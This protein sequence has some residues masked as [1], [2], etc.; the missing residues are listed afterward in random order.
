M[1]GMLVAA[2]PTREQKLQKAIHLMETKGDVNAALPLL[3]EAA[4]SSDRAVAARALLSLA[5]AQEGQ[6]K[7][8][9]R[10]TYERIAKDYADQRDVVAQARVRLKAMNAPRASIGLTARQVW[11]GSEVDNEGVPTPDGR[12]LPVVHWDSGDIAIRDLASGEMRRLMLKNSWQES[13]EYAEWPLMSPDQRHIVYAWFN[14][15]ESNY[16]VRVVGSEPGAKPRVLVRNPEFNYYTP[17]AWS[18]DGAT[19]LMHIW[20]RDNT[21]EIAW[22]STT[23]GSTKILKNFEWRTPALISLSPDGRYIAYDPLERVNGTDRDIVIIAADGS[24]ETLLINSPGS[25]S[26]PLWS[27]N[28]KHIVFTS[29]RGGSNGLWSIAVAGGKGQGAPQLLKSDV[30]RMSVLFTGAERRAHLHSQCRRR[31]RAFARYS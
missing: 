28:G 11:T 21:S 26:C 7:E 3:E 16:E 18:S 8:R 10:A 24:S 31:Y 20:R 9:A 19:I 17:A 15:T 2:D 6:G 4:R 23:N 25:D 29:T 12:L 13:L 30:G 27:P 22:V 5:Q 14:M 1:I